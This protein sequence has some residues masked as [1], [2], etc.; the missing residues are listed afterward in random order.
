MF[1]VAAT[2][3]Q[4]QSYTRLSKSGGCRH[5]GGNL[6]EPSKVLMLLVRMRAELL[7][8]EVILLGSLG[9]LIPAI[10][11]EVPGLLLDGCFSIDLDKF[12][13]C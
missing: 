1:H 12:E 10:L 4:A 5:A 3:K 6:P 11:A 13:V 8:Y 2:S 7:D 9:F